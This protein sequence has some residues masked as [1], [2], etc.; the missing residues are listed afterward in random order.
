MTSPIT[1]FSSYYARKAPGAQEPAFDI[2]SRGSVQQ[3]LNQLREEQTSMQAMLGQSPG[4]YGSW[5]E[6]RPGQIGY[7]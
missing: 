1:S 6:G 5:D 3:V 7:A 4:G 2:S